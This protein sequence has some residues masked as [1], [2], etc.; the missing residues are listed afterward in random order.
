LG[1]AGLEGQ[2]FSPILQL[3]EDPSIFGLFFFS[4]PQ[5]RRKARQPSLLMLG[6]QSIELR[7]GRPVHQLKGGLDLVIGKNI[8][9][10][11]LPQGNDESGS[12]ARD[13]LREQRNYR[14]KFVLNSMACHSL[15]EFEIRRVATL[16]E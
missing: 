9:E 1:P 16:S 10:R 5:R 14:R 12:Y 3:Q 11:R 4:R 8:E 6:A 13:D 7:M 15:G 2:Q